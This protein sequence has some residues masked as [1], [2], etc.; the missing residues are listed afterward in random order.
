MK[1]SLDEKEI[2]RLQDMFEYSWAL[3][4]GKNLIKKHADAAEAV[5]NKIKFTNE[6]AH[7][8]INTLITKIADLKV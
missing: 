2:Q 8:G 7:K 5:L 3:E 4:Y 1:K 6:D